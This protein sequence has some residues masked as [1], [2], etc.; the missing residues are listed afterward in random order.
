MATIIVE[1]GTGV[2]GANS[3]I[4]EAD[5]ATY[6]TD[7]GITITG[8]SAILLIQAMDWLEGQSFIGFKFTDDQPLLWPRA[9]VWLDN[10]LLSTDEIPQELIDG[11]AETA[12]SIDSGTGPLNN[13][14]RET[15]R[16]KVG[17]LEV[18][19]M[20]NADSAITVLTA[21]NKLRKLLTGTGQ[22]IEFEVY[23]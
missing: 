21:H 1:D 10:F 23:R 6:A 4:S 3:Y 11:L 20:D 13:V 19:Y 7:R 17:T 5:L 8:T 12:L 15:K 9:G 18:E 22:G 14:A 16:T 2:T